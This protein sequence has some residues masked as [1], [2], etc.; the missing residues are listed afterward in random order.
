[1]SLKLWLVISAVFQKLN[2]TSKMNHDVQCVMFLRLICCFK[3]TMSAN[4]LQYLFMIKL[5]ISLDGNPSKPLGNPGQTTVQY[6]TVNTFLERVNS[7][8]GSSEI[9]HGGSHHIHIGIW[10]ISFNLYSEKHAESLCVIQWESN[11]WHLALWSSYAHMVIE[12]LMSL[13]C[14]HHKSDIII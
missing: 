9:N 3:R 13:Y 8:L 11:L 12:W 10:G 6:N 5:S 7:L 4:Y 2:W 14:T 1:M